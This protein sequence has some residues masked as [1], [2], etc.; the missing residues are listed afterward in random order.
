MFVKPPSSFILILSVIFPSIATTVAA[1]RCAHVATGTQLVLHAKHEVEN[2][3]PSSFFFPHHC[4]VSIYMYLSQ[5]VFLYSISYIFPF[6]LTW[7]SLSTHLVHSSYTWFPL[8]TSTHCRLP[9]LLWSWFTSYFTS[10]ILLTPCMEVI[11]V[12]NEW[13]QSTWIRRSSTS[14]S[15]KLMSIRKRKKTYVSV[16]SHIPD[17][18]WF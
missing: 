12:R 7:A 17:T 11:F 5:S 14:L 10:L 13:L 3:L 16:L 15:T 18:V 1:P 8:I 9:V 6:C 4:R 2:N